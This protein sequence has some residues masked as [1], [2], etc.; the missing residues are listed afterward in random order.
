MPA[1]NTA[2]LFFSL[3]A[4]SV[5]CSTV[6]WYE[7]LEWVSHTGR[8]LDHHGGVS[9]RISTLRPVGPRTLKLVERAAQGYCNTAQNVEGELL[10]IPAALLTP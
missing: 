6:G 3:V 4:C 10:N 8:R 7:S 5:Y 2:Q 1:E 9:P